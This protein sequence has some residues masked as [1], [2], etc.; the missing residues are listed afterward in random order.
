[1]SFSP[2]RT[3]VLVVSLALLAAGAWLL[4]ARGHDGPSLG[5]QVAERQAA[6]GECLQA[7][8]REAKHEGQVERKGEAGGEREC[9]GAP[10]SADDVLKIGEAVTSRLG[11]S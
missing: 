9:P 4:L 2:R 11:S 10:E 3:L 1:M 7:R 6:I 5:R 8:A